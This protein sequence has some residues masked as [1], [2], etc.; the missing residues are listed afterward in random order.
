MDNNNMLELLETY[1]DLVEQQDVI[2]C[3]LGNILS[4]QAETLR[5]LESNGELSSPKLDEETKNAEKEIKD[6]IRTRDTES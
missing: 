4:R 3:R 2:I 6:Y 1:M 5:L